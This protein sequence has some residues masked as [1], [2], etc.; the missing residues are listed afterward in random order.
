[1]EDLVSYKRNTALP[2]MS[3][4]FDRISD[5]R[6]IDSWSKLQ[7][8]I[9][10]F[11]GDAKAIQKELDQF[12]STSGLS[13][14]GEVV[15]SNLRNYQVLLGGLLGIA[16]TLEDKIIGITCTKVEVGEDKVSQGAKDKLGK[17]RAAVIKGFETSLGIM[18]DN[19]KSHIITTQQLFRN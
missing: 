4:M 7:A 14:P 16:A 2:T 11:V 8:P 10:S 12:L 18:A 19:L 17:E 3:E 5:L 13:E 15:L 1:M 6:Y 9:D